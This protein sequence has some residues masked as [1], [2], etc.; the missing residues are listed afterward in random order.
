MAAQDVLAQLR[1]QIEQKSE[2]KEQEGEGE[3]DEG[4]GEVLEDEG[5][6]DINFFK[7][8]LSEA[9]A[10]IAELIDENTSLKA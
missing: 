7:N 2:K 8:K 5:S 10:Y 9:E 6:K 3:E 1:K 4:E